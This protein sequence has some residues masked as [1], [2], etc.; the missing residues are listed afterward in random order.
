MAWTT[1]PTFANNTVLQA[2]EMNIIRDDLLHLNGTITG[3]NTP[4]SSAVYG[5]TNWTIAQ[6]AWT[7]RRINRYLHWRARLTDS[8]TDYFRIFINGVQQWSDETDRSNPFTYQSGA[9]DNIDLDSLTS[10]TVN[11]GDIYTVHTEGDW[12]SAAPRELI[13]DYLWESDSTTL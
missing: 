5:S 9:S 3:V 11:V 12:T 6:G 1:P 8:D 7:F 4:F 13:L 10:I 2:S